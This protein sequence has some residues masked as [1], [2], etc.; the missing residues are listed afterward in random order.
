MAKPLDGIR[1]FD[2][3][4]AGVGPW[5]AKLL[6]ELGADVIHVEA[7]G[8]SPM[9]IPPMFGGT[10]ILY[11]TANSNK[12][13]IVLDLKEQKDR[14]AAYSLIRSCD[15]F[16]ENMRPGVM[17]R[18]GLDYESLSKVNPDLVYV[19]ASG[20]GQTGHMVPR[21]GADPQLQAYS[22]WDMITGT[23]E[24]GPEFFRHFAHL[25]YNTSQYIVQAV[26]LALFARARG[27]GG[28]K[29]EVAMLAAAMSL[30][31]S[32]ISEFLATGEQPKRLGSGTTSSVPQQAFQCQDRRWLA[33]GVT[34][35]AQW[36]PFCG[37]IGRADLA[38]DERFAT[39]RL[40]IE[41]RDQLVPILEAH[42]ATKPVRWWEM[43]LTE[44]GVPQG[45]FL[46]WNELRFHPQVVENAMMQH[47]DTP[48]W[49]HLYHEGVPWQFSKCDPITYRPA[50]AVGAHTEQVRAEIATIEAGAPADATV[51]AGT[52]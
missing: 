30:Q 47:E 9:A 52:N 50:P 32:R 39:N 46:S 3:T 29:I 15:V 4:L 21:P 37:A 38:Q 24:G 28:Q 40:R 2:I 11:V 22:G 34:D 8:R 17:E 10:S 44:A 26:L 5:S 23:E 14:Q 31:S 13:C 48:E 25:D 6:G 42:F 41:H 7:P 33:V 19:S 49:G 18:L 43:K 45:R 20:Y 36:A 51:K 12:R 35:D 1:V 16:V 27:N